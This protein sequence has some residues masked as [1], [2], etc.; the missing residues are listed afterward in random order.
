MTS[1][2]L[3]GAALHP[4]HEPA[5]LSQYRHIRAATETLVADLSDAD[6]TVQS[7]DDASPAKWHL[8]H[9][10]WFFE[11]FVLAARIPDYEPVDPAYRYLFNS[12][13]EAV[14]ARHPRPQRG[15]LTRPSLDEVLAYREAVDEAMLSLLGSAQ[16]DDEAALITLGL[17]HEQQH[18][19]LLLTDMLHLFAQNPLRPAFA[20]ELPAPV[21]ADPRPAP[22]W[23]GFDGGLVEVGHRGESFAFDCEG[24]RHK[25]YLAPFT[26]CSHP[27]SN[28]QW[29]EFI[30][31][32]GYQSTGL[33]L[34]DG[35]RWVGEQGIQAPLYWEERE[36]T[37]WQMTLRGMHPVDPDSPVTHVSFYEADAFARWAERRLPTEAE[38]EHAASRLP[39]TG[40][41]VEGRALRPLPDRQNTAGVLRQMFGDVWEW[42]ASA[43]LPYPGFRPNAGAVGEYNGKFMSG[44]MVLRGGSCVTPESHIRATY[45]NFF[46]PHQRWQ[47]TGVRLADDV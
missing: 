13:Y 19:E 35:W 45:R 33:W 15:L 22:D 11:E 28:R 47:F 39:A 24:P 12:Y 16:T 6:A 23:I 36:G 21:I 4:P 34:S 27:V 5:L 3:P 18:Q 26:L 44:Q 31:D 30:E 7:M 2:L 32:G 10:T 41:F 29:F 1:A 25:T 17:Q 37:W 46:Y 40:N 43:F 38:W 14:G 20:P 8:A 42:T 9:T